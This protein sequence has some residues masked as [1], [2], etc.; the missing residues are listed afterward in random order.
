VNNQL[1][2]SGERAQLA[3]RILI[4]PCNGDRVIDDMTTTSPLIQSIGT[5]NDPPRHVAYHVVIAGSGHDIPSDGASA[6]DP[7]R[8]LLY[9]QMQNQ[10][11]STKPLPL[12]QRKNL[13]FGPQSVIFCSSPADDHDL[14][15]TVTEQLGGLDPESSFASK[16][17]HVDPQSP[18][19]GH[20]Q[21]EHD[22]DHTRRLIELLNAPDH[23]AFTTSLPL[24]KDQDRANHCPISIAVPAETC[25]SFAPPQLAR[26]ALAGSSIG[27]VS[28]APGTAVTPGATIAVEVEVRGDV[29]PE[30][31]FIIAAGTLVEVEQAP[32]RVEVTIP[33]TAFDSVAIDAI[34]L[35]PDGDI[36]FAT[37]VP[38]VVNLAATLVSL[39]LPG[40]DVVLPRPGRTRQLTVLGK[41]SDGVE[42]DLTRA[43]RATLYGSSSVTPIASVS[44]DGLVTG[45][46]PG[47]ATIVARN[48]NVV[49]S[50][51]VLVGEPAC[52]DGVLD[53][54]EQCDD[55]NI[56]GG[57][58]CS[59]TCQFDNTAPVAV[60][61]SPTVCADPGRCSASVTTLGSRSFDPDGDALTISQAPPG[62]Y[63]VGEHAVA[64]TV[65]DSA[66][67][68]QCTSQLAV[69]DCEPPVLRCPADFAVECTSAGSAPVGPPAA[70]ATDN[71]GVTVQPPD[72]GRLAL[73]SHQLM[74]AASDPSDNRT[75]C[76][77]TVTVQDTTP[78]D[79]TCPAPIRAECLALSLAF[80]RPGSATSS[81]VCTAV[82]VTGPRTG[83]YPLGTTPIT[84]TA[85][86]QTGNQA[87]CH[88]AIEVVDTRPAEIFVNRTP[89]LSNP[90][91]QYRTVS[92]DDCGISVR[93]TCGGEL[94]PSTYQPAI[95][96]VTSD[97]PDDA[98]GP[99]DG[100]TINDIALV[101]RTRVKLRAERD[102]GRDGRTYKI[103]FRVQDRAGNPSEGTCTVLVPRDP[104]CDPRSSNHCRVGDSGVASSVCAR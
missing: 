103:H 101:D 18:L 25:P 91:H 14:F 23:S 68:S 49:T 42:R 35:Y 22:H 41:F 59:R 43:A 44:P 81:D 1:L 32:F 47:N 55:G 37:Q 57:D 95:T 40:G 75:R 20:F 27:I 65:S 8:A 72:A 3:K 90:D 78:P 24:P 9:K 13:I 50:I 52:G 89:V 64:V 12:L 84:Y 86:D 96:C 51:N 67:A 73:G 100:R 54:G 2:N 15:T 19:S 80:V 58:G 61:D 45:L 29:P 99:G 28:P 85:T 104:D 76:T 33:P 71:C 31:V 46:A 69:H 87:S 97:E 82:T 102:G 26:A 93:D 74:Y 7:D 48:G 92:L 77:T 53:P 88:T 98:P 63:A 39:R 5:H 70:T 83:L 66:L 4:D 60:C 21:I 30:A 94:A 79:I 11:P 62:P 38:L 34:A 36:A 56:T 10:H 6:L 17:F 16:P